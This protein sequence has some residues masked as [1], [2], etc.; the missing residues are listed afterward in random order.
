[1]DFLKNEVSGEERI[2]L[3][4]AGFGMSKEVKQSKER[5]A[6]RD[7]ATAMGLFSG[8]SSKGHKSRCLFCECD[9]HTSISCQKAKNMSYADVFK[10][11]KSKQCCFVCLRSGYFSRL[12]RSKCPVCTKRHFAVMCPDLPSR[13]PA[14][15][16]EAMKINSGLTSMANQHSYQIL[17]QTLL[18]RLCNGPREKTVRALIDTGSQ[19]SYVLKKTVSDLGYRPIGSQRISNCLVEYNR[20]IRNIGNM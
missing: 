17:L 3:A 15:G 11:V 18:V 4:R 14:L 5:T 8:E 13:A 6:K 1:M 20:Q 19:K 12:C 10:T 9:E 16:V 7:P 2:K